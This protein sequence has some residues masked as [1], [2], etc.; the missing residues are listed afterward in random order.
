MLLAALIELALVIARS[1]HPVTALR[2]GRAAVDELL[3]GL[4]TG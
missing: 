1:G 3:D 4:L 2:A